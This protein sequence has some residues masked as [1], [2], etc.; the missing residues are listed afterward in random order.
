[1]FKVYKT[2]LIWETQFP[3]C[4]YPNLSVYLVNS[5]NKHT[6]CHCSPLLNLLPYWISLARIWAQL[7]LGQ[8][9]KGKKKVL[10]QVNYE[11]GFFL[12]GAQHF[13]QKQ[14]WNSHILT[15]LTL[16]GGHLSTIM[17][18][19]WMQKDKP[20]SPAISWPRTGKSLTFKNGGQ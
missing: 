3:K 4:C 6:R 11:V 1:M 5:E 16:L 14:I 15:W 17:S 20:C 19:H 13:T 8:K 7:G 9:E 12:T 18:S 2:K 10:L